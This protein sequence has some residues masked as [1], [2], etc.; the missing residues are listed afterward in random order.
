MSSGTGVLAI[1]GVEI[2]KRVVPAISAEVEVVHAHLATVLIT[3]IRG[4][5]VLLLGSLVHH[6]VIIRLVQQSIEAL[7]AKSAF[8]RTHVGNWRSARVGVA[9]VQC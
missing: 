1:A 4:V 6:H 7:E 9:E 2:H 5:E 3:Q 8:I